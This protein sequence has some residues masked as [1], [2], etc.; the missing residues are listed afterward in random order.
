MSEWYMKQFNLIKLF[1]TY[2][3]IVISIAVVVVLITLRMVLLAKPDS[4]IEY[5]VKRESLVD[6]VQVTGTYKVAS[7]VAVYSPT[8]GIIKKVFVSN[9]KQV[10]KDDP[11]FEVES[12]ATSDEKAA[13]Y[14]SYQNALNTL[15]STENARK[16][17]DSTMWVKQ[18]TLLD[19]K[20]AV[21][22][23]NDHDINPSTK[24]EYTV[25]EEESL[26]T[27]LVQAE[28]DFRAAE[29]IYKTSD[30]AIASAQAAVRAALIEYNKTQSSV[31]KS[32]AAGTIQNF[33]GAVGD[34][35]TAKAKNESS[36]QNDSQS[37]ESPVLLITNLESPYI[38]AMTR[39]H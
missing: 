26:E 27:A 18:K 25:L 16:T 14:A 31:V 3:V 2:K 19:A 17:A 12:T 37:E 6:T 34:E 36:S 28:K 20:N 15:R 4:S 33:M 9:S 24:N 35:V 38:S 32:T 30:A 7:Q 10:K 23:K 29:E 1:N 22:Y 21:N 39:P 11:L 13:A 5:T 8:N